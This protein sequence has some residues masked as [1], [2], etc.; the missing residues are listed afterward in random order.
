LAAG[1]KPFHEEDYRKENSSLCPILDVLIGKTKKKVSAYVDTGCTSGIS[2]FKEQIKDLNIGEKINEDPIPV[3]MADGHLIGADVYKSTAKIGK[4][5]KDILIVA[6]DPEKILGSAPIEKM[7]PLLGRN[8]LDNF[9]VLF[10]GKDKK[11][12]LF[13]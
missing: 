5:K 12:A 13:K 2:L 8:F 3:L 6:V 9:D 1:S 4:V 11:I 7:T 10:K